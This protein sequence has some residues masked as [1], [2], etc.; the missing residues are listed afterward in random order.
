MYCFEN[1]WLWENLKKL[2]NHNAQ[3]EYYLTD[4]VKLAFEQNLK[5]NTFYLDP[6]EAIGI[7]SPE[8]L[9][10]AEKLV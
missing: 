2:D 1:R 9:A 3:R 4:L 8:E 7:N 10:I 6:K 5:I